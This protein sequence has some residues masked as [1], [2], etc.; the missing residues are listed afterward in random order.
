M[1]PNI[2]EGDL[3]L[4]DDTE[5]TGFK[6]NGDL[7]QD[8][9]AR[10]C[11]IGLILAD[12][13]G[14]PRLKFKALIKPDGWTISEGAQKVHGITM[15]QCEKYGL[16]FRS[17]FSLYRRLA[18][19]SKVIIAHND[20]FDRGMMQ[21]EEAYFNQGLEDDKKSNVDAPWFCTMRS[22]THIA[23]GKW[24]KLAA[25]L[26][27][28]TGRDLGGDAHDALADVEACKDIFFEMLKQN[29]AAA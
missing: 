23:G 14:I 3:F 19:M 18:G 6:K 15:E 2:Q 28:Y 27:H 22:N 21:I 4:F 5:T 25:T 12:W 17:V 20:E 26:K 29:R 11:Q 1:L 24:P 7:I 10:V 16:P 8:G 13:Q 9:Q